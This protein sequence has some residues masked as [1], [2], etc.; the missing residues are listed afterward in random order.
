M[1]RVSSL[2]L[3][4]STYGLVLGAYCSTRDH[5]P[6]LASVCRAAERGVW[7]LTSVAMTTA[8]PLIGRLEPQRKR[9]RT[10]LNRFS[11]V[12]SDPCN[13]SPSS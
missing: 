1:G 7:A 12:D 2:P 9:E 8:Q 13:L 6:V 11:P 5:H 4:S 3:V 10:R